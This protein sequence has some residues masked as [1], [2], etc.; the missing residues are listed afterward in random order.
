M[1]YFLCLSHGVR[2]TIQHSMKVSSH[3][4][5]YFSKNKLKSVQI[6]E[7]LHSVLR[8]LLHLPACL[9]QFS[10]LQME[11]VRSFKCPENLCQTTRRHVPDFGALHIQRDEIFTSPKQHMFDQRGNRGGLKV[12]ILHSLLA[13]NSQAGLKEMGTAEG[14]YILH[15]KILF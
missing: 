2:C 7:T 10:T 14:C 4:C 3:A 1:H 11:A 12:S 8:T 5:R 15:I 6:Y 9:A 13:V